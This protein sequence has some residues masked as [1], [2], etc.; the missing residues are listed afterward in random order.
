MTALTTPTNQARRPSSHEIILPRL[1]A[2]QR[3][4]R[5]HPA[6]FKVLACGRR[7]GKTRLGSA[8][9]IASALRGGRAWWVAPSYKVAAVGW[10][11]IKHLGSQIPGAALREG[12]RI[13]TLPTGGT[14]QVRSADEPDSLRGDGLNYLVMDECAFIT[15]AAWTEALRP[16]LSD[17]RGH[18]MFISTPKG[19]NWFWRL[20][21]RGQ[22]G[23]PS[24]QSWQF[25]TQ[26]NPFIDPAEIEDARS[27]LPERIHDQ[28]YLARF[29]E[30]AGGV[31]RGV[32]E[33]I[34][35]G[36][37]DAE[38]PVSGR[39]Y[40]LGVDLARVEDFTVLCVLDEGGRQVYFER[41]N[42]ISWERQI[43][44]VVD[45]AG[46]YNKARTFLDSTGV[47]DPIFEALR[48]RGVDVAGFQFTNQNKEQLIDDLAMGIER[49]DRRL[50]DLPTQTNELFAYQ[51][52]LT[53]SRNVR[54]NAPEGM[55]DDCVI[56]L[57]LAGWGLSHPGSWYA[58]PTTQ[59]QIRELMLGK[60]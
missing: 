33:A 40:H 44:R 26:S 37:K 48:K 45:V 19:M 6:R 11:G 56:A 7:W 5:D 28:E 13:L 53:P 21:V 9:C 10:R 20:W 60:R 36:R 29:L 49:G 23:D 15:E 12:D 38:A 42:Q 3:E 50:M 51:Y 4:V 2:G 54:M 58:D 47:G 43:E 24:W 59:R 22:E 57:A 14:V 52:E 18:A 16:A 39:R 32:R 30:E 46:R 17:R 55:H 1:H 27:L 25:P 41:F 31:F 35:A 8:L 34:D